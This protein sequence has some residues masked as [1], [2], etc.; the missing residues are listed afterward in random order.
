M[1]AAVTS[2]VVRVS[3]AGLLPDGD[4]VHVDDAVDAVVAVLQL[5][6]VDDRAEVVAEM[7][8]PGRLHAGENPLG[9]CHLAVPEILA[10]CGGVFA[11]ARVE[12]Q[13]FRHSSRLSES[14]ANDAEVNHPEQPQARRVDEHAERDQR[15]ERR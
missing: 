14:A 13:V 7:Q 1:N 11:T 10:V 5:H 3:S 2:R 8:I 15:P 4:R 6:E 12:A 9:Q